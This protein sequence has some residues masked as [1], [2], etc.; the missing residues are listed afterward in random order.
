[1]SC[2]AYARLYI[3][4]EQT[5]DKI[6]PQKTGLQRNYYFRKRKC[7]VSSRVKTILKL[8][9][10]IITKDI[11][12]TS[13][14]GGNIYTYIKCVQLWN[15]NYNNVPWG[16]QKHANLEKIA[17]KKKAVMTTPTNPLG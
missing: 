14:K 11:A 13:R 3:Y 12:N 5:L 1:M 7:L 8:N 10:P 2:V 9:V 4:T 17:T 6:N 15:A 16:I